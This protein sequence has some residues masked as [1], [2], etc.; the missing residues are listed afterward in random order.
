VAIEKPDTGIVVDGSFRW[1]KSELQYQVVDIETAELIYTSPVYSGG[2]SNVAEYLAIIHGLAH[3]A[4][5]GLKCKVYTDSYVAR[6]WI[7]QK[8]CKTGQFMSEEL[9]KVVDRGTL[10]L[11]LNSPS[12]KVLIWQSH[13]WGENPADFGRK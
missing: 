7:V 12:N 9:K 3:A 2:S 8:K 10:W 5:N 13:L 6:R 4:K 1:S 11:N